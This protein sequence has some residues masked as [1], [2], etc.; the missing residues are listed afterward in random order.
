MLRYIYIVLYADDIL[1][2]TPTV[3]EL[4]NLLNT[5]EREL[6]ALGLVINVKKSCCLRIGPRNDVNCERL[7]SVWHIPAMDERGQIL[8]HLS[9]KFKT[10]QNLY[11][12]HSIDSPSTV[13]LTLYLEE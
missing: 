12:E 3:S 8:R 6:Q 1:L 5:C 11:T 13:R 9:R 7:S 10:F 2:L 4:Q